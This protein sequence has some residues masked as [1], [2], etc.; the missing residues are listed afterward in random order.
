[1]IPPVNGRVMRWCMMVSW[2]VAGRWWMVSAECTSS[3][4]PVLLLWSMLIV[5][6]TFTVIFPTWPNFEKIVD[7]LDWLGST[8]MLYVPCIP[9]NHQIHLDHSEKFRRRPGIRL[10]VQ[11]GGQSTHVTW[12]ITISYCRWSR[13]RAVEITCCAWTVQHRSN[14]R[15]TSYCCCRSCRLHGSHR[16][17]WARSYRSYRSGIYSPCLADVH[18]ELQLLCQSV[19]LYFCTGNR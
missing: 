14:P 1:M 5:I 3:N 11:V 7:S 12:Q 6:H 17:T 2:L 8:S 15:T 4:V 16:A 10:R 19:L 13:S 9:G 18:H